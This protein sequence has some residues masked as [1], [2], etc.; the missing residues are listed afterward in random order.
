MRTFLSPILAACFTLCLA[1]ACSRDGSI[2]LDTGSFAY[3]IAPD[4]KNLHFIDSSTGVDYCRQD[5]PSFCMELKTVGGAVHTPSTVTFRD[6]ILAAF[7]DSAGVTARIRVT[8]HDRHLVLMVESVEGEAGVESLTFINLPLTLKGKP[9]EP[10]GAC[11]FALDTITRVPELPALQSHPRATCYGRY[12]MQGSHAALV[13]APP[14]DMLPTLRGIVEGADE[15]P[16]VDVA[17]AWAREVPF[18]HG[19]Y[20]FNFGTLTEENVDEWIDMATSLGF[21]QIDN[22]GGGTRFFRFGDFHLN[23][24]KWPGGWKTYKRIVG[25]LHDAGIGSILH[26]YAFFIDKQSE[27]VTPAPHPGLDAFRSFTLAEPV[28]ESATE[29]RVIE[30]TADV[31]TITGFFERNSVTLHIGDELVTFG[32]V[33]KDKPYTFTGCTRGAYGTKASAHPAETK[34][35]H[36]KECFGLFVPDCESPLFEEIARRHAGIVDDCGFDG[37]YLDAID[38]SDILR[39]RSE[40]WYWGQ[41]FVYLIYKHLKKPVGMEMSAMWHQMWNFRTRWQAWD[42]PS[43]GHKRFVDVHADA[44]NSGLLLPMHLGWW[45]FLSFSPPQV[46]PTYPDVIEYLGCRLIGFDAGLSLTGAVNAEQLGTVP[47]YRR[48]VDLLKTYEDLRHADYFDD[49]VKARLREPGKEFTLFRDAGDRWRFKPVMYAR[50]SITAPV[51][52]SNAWTVENGFGAQPA[53]L[54]IEA[55]MSAGPYDATGNITLAGCSGSLD[56]FTMTAA[57]GVT[58]GTSSSTDVPT[59]IPSGV[60]L[61][62]KSTGAVPRNASWAKAVKTFNPPLDLNK[63]QAIGV[64]INGDGK[65]EILNFRLESPRHIAY[66]AVADR[67]VTVDFTGWRYIE[68]IETE[69]E[70]WSDYV[71]NDGKGMYN[72]YRELI[73]FDVVESLSIWYNNLPPG[74]E[75]V[76][77]IGPVN[78]LPMVPCTLKNPTVTVNGTTVVFPVTMKSGDVIEYGGAGK[79]IHYGPKGEVLAEITPSGGTPFLK[80]G[81]NSVSFKYAAVGGPTPR[82]RVTVIG[83][84]DPL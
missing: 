63:H 75:A 84:G 17:G 83:Y 46:E 23:E 77:T 19:S 61:R 72:V 47:L 4:G 57:E 62:A 55:L 9:D 20:L 25:R 35:R 52:R 5:S 39:G 10:F 37:F 28:D 59:S 56:G 78:A 80:A 18:N 32:G 79:C 51:D 45:N 73:H 81:T 38:G 11:S 30:S 71:W 2:T 67:Y 13:G 36:L 16:H 74:E 48:L 12:G 3:V 21:N 50:H 53:S 66:G 27:Y 22:H 44:V 42:Y 31:S 60:T 70:R 49:S 24:E 40:S 82:A 69:S 15:L 54:R 65:G 68:L 7:F 26:T 41:K 14:D 43:R 6:G 76:C 33:T 64:W 58:F 1:A 8:G 34:V 29:L